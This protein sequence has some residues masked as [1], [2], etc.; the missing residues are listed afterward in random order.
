[1]DAFRAA[2]PRLCE[3]LEGKPFESDATATAEY[4]KSK[5][6][7][8]AALEGR[9]FALNELM[10][11]LC[12]AVVPEWANPEASQL[13]S[14]LAA[15]VAAVGIA[16]ARTAY[17]DKFLVES[18][19]KFRDA[20]QKHQDAKNK[21]EDLRYEIAV[22]AIACAVLDSGSIQLEKPIPDP[23]KKEKDWKNSDVFGTFQD[24]PVR[25]EV[26]VLHE[27]LPPAIHVELDEIVRRAEVSSGFAVALRSVLVD[28]D[29][30]ERVRALL[31]LLHECHVASDGKDE[32]IDGVRFE[33][34][35]GAYHS[36]ETSPF[37]SICF[38][39][40]DE[41]HGAE[42][43]REIIHPCSVRPVT[44][45]YILEDDPNPPG[46]I[47]L[48]DLPGAPIQVPVST[49][50]HQMLD[51]KR[52]QCEDGLINMVAFGNPL[53]MHDG[54]V[55]I[56]VCGSE[57][58]VVPFWTD[59]NGVRH[60]GKGVLTSDPKAPFVPAHYLASDDDRRQFIDPFKRMSAVWHIRIGGHAKSRVIP[61]PNTLI[62]VPQELVK[63]LSDPSP[64]AQSTPTDDQVD[65]YTPSAEVSSEQPVNSDQEQDIVWPEVAENYV[66]VCETLSEARSV[67]AHL[68]Q[69]GLPLDE[70]RRK[71]EQ[72]WP[73]PSK[74]DKETKFVSPTNDEMAMTFV[75]DCGGYEQAKACLEAYAEEVQ[76]QSREDI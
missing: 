60:S 47:T 67:L 22:T 45:N 52:Q 3:L 53:P 12:G 27:S 62:P 65:R 57:V 28:I 13:E 69:V 36:Q 66:Q 31:E 11:L 37:E 24:H 5:D 63:V 59:K 9:V 58:G 26:T 33:W 50:V 49:K 20:E 21:L 48:A 10:W 14:D 39:S 17:R 23:R 1:M 71:V 74:Q 44:S 30:A 46:V 76:G 18:K 25:I 56:A 51:G 72:L 15:I 8:K 55:L 42:K 7:M 35:R 43:K 34:K 16:A 38:Y 68:E 75:I 41:F 70:L 19:S 73:E 29:Y 4:A 2:F 40:P 54:E 61:N 64:S 6:D 32:E